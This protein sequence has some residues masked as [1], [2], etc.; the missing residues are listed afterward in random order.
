MPKEMRIPLFHNPL[1]KEK[2][3]TGKVLLRFDESL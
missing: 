3:Q 1:K 2:K